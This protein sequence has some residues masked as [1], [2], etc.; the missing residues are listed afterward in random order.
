M[1]LKLYPWQRNESPVWVN[2]ENG[3]EWYI[4]EYLTSCCKSQGVSNLPELNA[5]CAL[6]ASVENDQRSPV[7]FVL[8]DSK[9][10]VL[11]HS[12]GID[13]MATEIFRIRLAMKL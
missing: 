11:A 6:V 5:L 9:R 7:G 2:P 4:D 8:L 10:N 13:T 3:M 12:E 1:E